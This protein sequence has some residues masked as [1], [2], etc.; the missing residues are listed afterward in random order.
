MKVTDLLKATKLFKVLQ[1]G[2]TISRPKFNEVEIIRF[3]KTVDEINTLPADSKRYGN[4]S[5]AEYPF[6]AVF[7]DLISVADITISGRVGEV[8]FVNWSSPEDDAILSFTDIEMLEFTRK[9]YSSFRTDVSDTYVN[10]IPKDRLGLG[11][12]LNRITFDEDRVTEDYSVDHFPI[13]TTGR[14]FDETKEGKKIDFAVALW[15]D[16]LIT[17]LTKK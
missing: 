14:F 2:A 13:I 17:K 5:L 11:E 16:N 3:L 1:D 4:Y 7:G 10:S 8:S 12:V 6:P 15:L 9:L